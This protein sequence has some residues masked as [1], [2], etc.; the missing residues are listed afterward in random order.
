MTT[1]TKPISKKKI[2]EI[3]SDR[4]AIDELSRPEQDLLWIWS[5]Q[6]RAR[7]CKTHA[8]VL[9]DGELTEEGETFCSICNAHSVIPTVKLRGLLNP[10]T[11]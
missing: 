1:E 4:E 6:S 11:E 2:D 10:Y 3:I 9:Y 7:Y 5:E 8:G